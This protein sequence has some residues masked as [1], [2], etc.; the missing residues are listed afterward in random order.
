MTVAVPFT[1]T[2]AVTVSSGS[3]PAEMLDRA[4]HEADAIWRS[5]GVTI[6]WRR[7]GALSPSSINV[8]VVDE[9]GRADGADLAVAWID[10]VDN[11]PVP[12]VYLSVPSA[13][14]LFGK[15]RYIP[16]ELEPVPAARNVVI[17]RALGRALAH[18]IGHFLLGSRA[19]EKGGVMATERRPW[20]LFAP[21]RTPFLV[22]AAE[23]RKLVE[24][25]ARDGL[26]RYAASPVRAAPAIPPVGERACPDKG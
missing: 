2:I 24:A 4:M 26:P 1:L 6:E 8:W 21:D 7:D 22:S 13:V 14:E 18:E 19:H 16:R 17:G 23:R 12:D 10:V 25:L 5:A 15:A 11:R 3:V 20:E 9:R